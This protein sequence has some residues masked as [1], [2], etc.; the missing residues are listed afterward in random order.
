MRCRSALCVALACVGWIA[1][2][3]A[4]W[5][6]SSDDAAPRPLTGVLARIKATGV[7]RLGYRDSA[8]PFSFVS[9]DGKP[10]GYSIDLCNAIVEDLAQATGAASLKVDYRRV[11]PADRFDQIADGRIDLECGS[12]TANAERRARAA[13]S[14]MIFVT[15][16]RLLVRHGSGIR[17][18]R[19]LA[20]RNVLVVRGTTNEAAMRTLA[21]NARPSFRVVLADDYAQALERMAGSDADAFAADD[22]VLA[23]M[24][25]ERGLGARYDIVGGLLSYEPYAIMFARDDPA[26]AAVVQD[27]FARLAASRELRWIYTRWFEDRL[28]SGARLRV[29]MGQ[30]LEG[31]F[32]MLGLPPE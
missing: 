22:I 14:P 27:S 8:V 21:S 20:D 11:T 24:L 6:Q 3:T 29:P 31:A 30:E 9:G 7:V 26:L 12:T 13:F 23:G 25:A 28:P 32:E 16:T 2:S 1:C 19:E 17:S 10:I 4:A 18:I 5:A 15:G